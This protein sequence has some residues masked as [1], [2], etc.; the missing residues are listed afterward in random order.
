M[1][2]ILFQSTD[3][4]SEKFTKLIVL[5]GRSSAFKCNQL[6]IDV[7][8]DNSESVNIQLVN[9]RL[10]NGIEFPEPDSDRLCTSYFSKLKNVNFKVFGNILTQ[11][12]V[13][14][15]YNPLKRKVRIYISMLGSN[16]SE[17]LVGKE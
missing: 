2:K 3:C 12:L 1:N 8:D 7:V 9:I 4:Q 13:F 5:S 17:D 15:F 6:Q 11:G 10:M 14:E 16:V